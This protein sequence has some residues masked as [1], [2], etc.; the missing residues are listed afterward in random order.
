MRPVPAPGDFINLETGD[1]IILEVENHNGN[2]RVLASRA[3]PFQPFA[4]WNWDPMNGA[5]YSGHYFK[6]LTEAE[7][8]Y[9]E[10]T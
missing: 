1:A 8:Y 4:V 3:H 10:S 9:W 5:F 2:I 7:T 6:T